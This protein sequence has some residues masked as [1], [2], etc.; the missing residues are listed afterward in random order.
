MKKQLKSSCRLVLHVLLGFF[1]SL[2][3]GRII[4]NRAARLFLV[5]DS[6]GFRWMDDQ[7]NKGAILP[8]PILELPIPPQYLPKSPQKLK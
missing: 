8:S 3:T 2:F 4:R 7:G 5:A 1:I 6:E